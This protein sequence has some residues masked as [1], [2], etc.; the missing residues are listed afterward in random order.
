MVIKNAISTVLGIGVVFA[1]ELFEKLLELLVS[2]RYSMVVGS[3]FAF[4][5]AKSL[6][7]AGLRYLF[8]FDR[9]RMG[10]GVGD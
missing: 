7:V 6:L 8:Y 2:L 10:F 1:V 9:E 4:V 5:V 3:L